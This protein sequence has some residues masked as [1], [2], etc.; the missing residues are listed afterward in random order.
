M[1]GKTMLSKTRVNDKTG[2]V[3]KYL[4]QQV[5]NAALIIFRIVFGILLFI[6]TL[7]ALLDKSFYHNFIE[8]PFTFTYIGF[9][10]LEPLH[11]NGMYYFAVIMLLLSVFIAA[12]FFY[13]ISM[14]LFALMWTTLYLMQKS[15]YNNH[16]Y[17]L[18]L[19]CWAMV[20]FPANRRCSV[21]ANRN[22]TISSNSCYRYVQLFFIFQMAVMYIYAGFNKLS[23]DWLSGKYIAIQFSSLSTH[24]FTGFLYGNNAFQHFICYGGIL[25]DLCIIPLMLWKKTRHAA[26]VI[27]CSFHLFNAYTF[28]IGIFP[29]LCIALTFF[30]FE[31]D[32]IQRKFSF[33]VKSSKNNFTA[34]LTPLFRKFL[35]TIFVIYCLFQ[36]LIP[37]RSLL[38]PG[39]VFWTEEGYRLSWKMMLRTKS[40]SLHYKIKDP[41]TGNTW[42]YNPADYFSRQQMMWMS[43]SPDIIW[44]VAQ[45]IKKDY[46]AKG[47]PN[48]EVYAIS[49]VSLNRSKPRPLIDS[50]INL[51]VVK[52][53]PFTHARWI[54]SAPE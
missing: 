49:A 42:Q 26:F 41:A 50:T 36:L 44:Q 33:F 37:L 35:I 10:W 12:G 4:F 40:G 15:G 13:R 2:F 18:L 11:G 48:A 34:G 9:E 21:D 46:E 32:F 39:N 31:P 6:Q 51:A 8:P 1:P 19:L 25:F 29:F 17:L 52:W 7:T 45:R 22:K 3:E 38:F 43:I 16:Y 5:N 30:F 53:Q 23:A 20:F 28:R 24:R 27:C 54:T 14:L 47:I